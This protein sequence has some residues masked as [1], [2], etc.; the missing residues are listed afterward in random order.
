MNVVAEPEKQDPDPV[1]Q[2]KDRIRNQD[3]KK[4]RI[5]NQ[6]VKKKRILNQDVKKDRIRN[7]DVKRQDPESRC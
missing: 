4:D 7:Q 5:Q 1:C 6:D 3:V 2:K